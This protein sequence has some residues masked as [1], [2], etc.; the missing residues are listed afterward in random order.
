M[1]V[2]T[3]VVLVA[4]A[5]AAAAS[6]QVVK[7]SGTV[8]LVDVS[9]GKL[10]VAEVGPWQRKNGETVT[11]PRQIVLTP[12]TEVVLA[13]REATAWFPDE[14]TTQPLF[15]ALAEGDF[16][17]VECRHEGPRWIALR[18]VVVEPEAP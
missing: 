18:I 15:R 16:V 6:A 17:T 13:R 12:E 14:Y 8:A 11:T 9:A 2:V 10:V 5:L 7:H 1:L 4:V 3:A